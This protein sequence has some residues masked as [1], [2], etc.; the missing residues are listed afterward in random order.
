MAKE[1]KRRKEEEKDEKR[2]DIDHYPSFSQHDALSTG[3]IYV[4][5]CAALYRPAQTCQHPSI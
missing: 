1:R 4:T 5:L 3:G 2:Q